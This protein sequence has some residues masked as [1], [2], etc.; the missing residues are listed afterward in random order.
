[1]R[2]IHGTLPAPTLI[3]LGRLSH[4]LLAQGD[5]PGG[6]AMCGLGPLMPGYTVVG[7]SRHV[8]SGADALLQSGSGFLEFVE[9]I[10]HLLIGQYGSCLMT[11]HGRVP[12]CAGRQHDPHCYHAHFL[13][14]PGAPEVFA[15]HYF[16]RTYDYSSLEDSLRAARREREYFLISQRLGYFSV[17]T[18][19]TNLIR[20]FSRMLVA[21]AI[22]QPALAN[23]RRHEQRDEVE[24][25]ARLLRQ[26]F[27]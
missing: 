23:W 16:A 26:T 8:R 25:T 5:G 19:P 11:E 4:R 22:G 20:Q 7:S 3:S 27:K 18:R 17:M 6:S 1:M 24:N 9:E 21:D 15:R 2:F 12:V 14:F 13:M 10:R